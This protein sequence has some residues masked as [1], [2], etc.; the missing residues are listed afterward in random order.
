MKAQRQHLEK[1]REDYAVQSPASVTPEPKQDPGTAEPVA[2]ENPMPGTVE[3][4]QAALKDLRAEPASK[5][6]LGL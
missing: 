3:E 4:L 1:V 6:Q 5:Q 2:E